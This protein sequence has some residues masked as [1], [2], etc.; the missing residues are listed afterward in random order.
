MNLFEVKVVEFCKT[1]GFKEG[2]IKKVKT[3]LKTESDLSCF[4]MFIIMNDGSFKSNLELIHNY[5]QSVD[6]GKIYSYQQFSEDFKADRASALKNISNG[7]YN[8][9]VLHKVENLLK[10]DL[11]LQDIYDTIVNEKLNIHQV[12]TQLSFSKKGVDISF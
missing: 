3:V 1:L 12:L 4:K 5:L 9:D 11:T 2:Q 6:M 10:I 8:N 7:M